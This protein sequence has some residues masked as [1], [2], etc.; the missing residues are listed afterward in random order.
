MG[1][2]AE[3][4]IEGFRDIASIQRSLTFVAFHTTGITATNIFYD[5]ASRPDCIE[6]LGEEIK[7]VLQDFNGVLNNSAL[8]RNDLN[9][10]NNI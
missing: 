8:Q 2:G 5:L 7:Q 6:P 1:K 4:E 10:Q 3:D 9:K